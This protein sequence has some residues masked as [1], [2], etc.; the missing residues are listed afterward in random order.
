MNTLNSNPT[1]RY[2]THLPQDATAAEIRRAFRALSIVLH[3]D[4][5]DA[6]DANVQFRNLVS[7]YE[8]LKDSSKREKYVRS[9][10]RNIKSILSFLSYVVKFQIQRST[11]KWLAKLEIGRVL[12]SSRA[13]NGSDRNGNHT[14]RHHYRLPIYHIVGCICREKVHSGEFSQMKSRDFFQYIHQIHS[15]LGVSARNEIAKIE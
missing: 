2:K 9:R 13:Q 6:E 11:E 14:F 8:V 4:K 7:V 1:D 3:P 5:N 12:L 10:Q 15:I